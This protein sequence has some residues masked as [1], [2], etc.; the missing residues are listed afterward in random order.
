MVL[1]ASYTASSTVIREFSEG[2]NPSVGGLSGLRQLGLNIGMRT[3]KGITIDNYPEILRSWDVQLAIVRE[4]YQIAGYGNTLTF[5]DYIEESKGLWAVIKGYTIGLPSKIMQTIRS[6]PETG[7]AGLDRLTLQEQAATETLAEMMTIKISRESGTL[8]VSVTTAQPILSAQLVRNMIKHL[9]LRVRYLYGEKAHQN[10]NFLKNRLG[11][12]KD[13]LDATEMAL[14]V[15]IDRNRNPQTAS[16]RVE[17]ARLNRAVGFNEQV[18]AQLKIQLTQAEFDLQR[19]E[20]VVTI[21]QSPIIP[22]KPSGPAR[23]LIV[24][25][26]FI[27]GFSLGIFAIIIRDLFQVDGS[28]STSREEIAELREALIPKFVRNRN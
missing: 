26:S 25:M 14:A 18:H 16:L 10:I 15:F 19:N 13:S 7:A 2:N 20:P 5:I 24:I 9:S 4:R 8:N 27:M 21:L 23:K 1:P 12:S 22:P 3:G 6:R 17:I 11:Q 28:S